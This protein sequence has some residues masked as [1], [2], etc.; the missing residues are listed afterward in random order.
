MPQT[1]VPLRA[2]AILRVASVP[3]SRR[4]TWR[5]GPPSAPIPRYVGN[6]TEGSA[7]KRQFF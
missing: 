5:R 2:G 1:F 4:Y 7:L 6:L 3:R